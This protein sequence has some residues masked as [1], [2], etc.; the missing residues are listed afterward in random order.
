MTFLRH[1]PNNAK[2]PMLSPSC[3][4]SIGFSVE[5]DFIYMNMGAWLDFVSQ[6]M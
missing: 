3:E 1:R 6:I 5:M 4:E 2:E